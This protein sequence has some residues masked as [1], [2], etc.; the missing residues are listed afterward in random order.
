MCA[1]ACGLIGTNPIRAAHPRTTHLCAR[2]FHIIIYIYMRVPQLRSVQA[3]H[4]AA[5]I[6]KHNQHTHTHMCVYIIMLFMMAKSAVRCEHSRRHG[7][8]A[9]IIN[10]RAA[11]APRSINSYEP[12]SG[13]QRAYFTIQGITRRV[14]RTC[15][16]A[17]T[18]ASSCAHE[19]A[20]TAIGSWRVASS[21]SSPPSPLSLG[22][23]TNLNVA[24]R[25][26]A[27]PR[28]CMDCAPV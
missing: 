12:G 9:N 24:V 18:Q 7:Y 17:R 4:D 19:H 10:P 13:E 16:H 23:K 1:R 2:D 11:R 20:G 5:Y 3:A 22:H 25:A 21:L 8:R 14:T 6:C 15:A 28:V 27:R 26:R